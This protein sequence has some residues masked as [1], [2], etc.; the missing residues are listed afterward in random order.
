ME[1]T[2]ETLETQ[3]LDALELHSETSDVDDGSAASDPAANVEQP[4]APEGGSDGSA[5]EGAEAEALVLQFGDEAPPTSASEEQQ[6]APQWVKDLRKD[7][8]AA[9]RRIREF[10]AKERT[11]QQPQQTQTPTLGPKPK[12]DE[13]DYDEGKFDE[14]LGKWYADK[15]KVDTADAE[16]RQAEEA[17]QRAIQEKHLG[18]ARE[19]QELRVKD[20]PDAET[21]VV[22]ALSVEQQGILLA[23]ADKPALLVYALGRYPTKLQQLAQIKDPVRFAFAAAKLEKELKVTSNRTATKPA[24]EGRVSSSSGAP[25]AG[26]GERKLEQLRAEAEKTGD[27][28]KVH[29]YKQQLKQAQTR[30]K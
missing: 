25:A 26:G 13:F 8:A 10:E 23:G 27:Y 19:A 21:E 28:S 17:R 3:D 4:E 24:P 30:R 14:A 6:A 12:L 2:A 11:Q 20:F 15:A 18:Y 16:K 7:Y 9:Q 29:A 22:A 5:G 1:N